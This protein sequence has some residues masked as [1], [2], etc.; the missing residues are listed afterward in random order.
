VT[1]QALLRLE[2]LSQKVLGTLCAE[3]RGS[4][5]SSEKTLQTETSQK[6]IRITI[7]HA[8]IRRKKT[9][10]FRVRVALTITQMTLLAQNSHSG[11]TIQSVDLLY[12]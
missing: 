4:A 9:F 11:L 12:L 3:L 10:L 5:I 1:G 8:F 7:W 6:G 2:S